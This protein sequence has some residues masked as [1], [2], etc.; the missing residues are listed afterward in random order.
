[1]LSR[2]SIAAA[3]ATVA[4]AKDHYVKTTFCP[5]GWDTIYPVGC[6]APLVPSAFCPTSECKFSSDTKRDANCRCKCDD[7]APECGDTTLRR[8]DCTCVP[9]DAYSDCP[10]EKDER[11]CESGKSWS[12]L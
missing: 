1:M 10:T 3:C 5:A 7:N 11:P 2:L 9:K 8:A 4:F 12:Q 6:P